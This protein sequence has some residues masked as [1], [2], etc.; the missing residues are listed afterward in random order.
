MTEDPTSMIERNR[1][2]ESVNNYSYF[3]L[4]YCNGHHVGQ[5]II[6]RPGFFLMTTAMYTAKHCSHIALSG[7]AVC[8]SQIFSLDKHNMWLLGAQEWVCTTFF[9]R[10]QIAEVW[11]D[12]ILSISFFG[13]GGTLEPH[14]H[15]LG[16]ALW[17]FKLDLRAGPGGMSNQVVGACIKPEHHYSGGKKAY[18]ANSDL[19]LFIH[20]ESTP[21]YVL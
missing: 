7:M 16:Y 1:C 11:L 2:T 21:H 13:N 20:F 15:K 6:V 8:P 3:V 17:W 18:E 4:A 19:Q 9:S 10:M 14:Y 5:H 12:S